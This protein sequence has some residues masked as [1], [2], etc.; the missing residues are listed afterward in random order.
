MSEWQSIET[1]PQDGTPILCNGGC[2]YKMPVFIAAVYD[3]FEKGWF[4]D[5]YEYDGDPLTPTHWMPLP[6]PPTKD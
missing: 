6:P 2:G 3:N 5:S 1:A 4:P